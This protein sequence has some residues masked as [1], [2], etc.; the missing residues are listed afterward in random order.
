MLHKIA[1][2]ILVLSLFVAPGT[3]RAAKSDG[4]HK[5][6]YDSGEVKFESMYEDGKLNGMTK[7]YA[8]DGTLRAKYVFRDGQVISKQDMNTPQRDLG[9]MSFVRSW[10]FWAGMAGLLVVGGFLFSKLVFK[11]RPF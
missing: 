5:T 11:N 6:Y 7:E 9:G 10:G 8:K 3:A 1:I 2:F 4:I